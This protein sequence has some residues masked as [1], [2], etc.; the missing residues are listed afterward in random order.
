MMVKQVEVPCFDEFFWL[1]V[2][3]DST[4]QHQRQAIFHGS[5]EIILEG[6]PGHLYITHNPNLTTPLKTSKDENIRSITWLVPFIDDILKRCQYIELDASFKAAFP[7]VYTVPLAIIDNEAVPLGFT[8]GPTEKAELFL[9]FYKCVEKT[10]PIYEDLLKIPINT[11]EGNALSLFRRTLGL[12]QFLCDN[13]IINKFGNITLLYHLV[14]RLLYCV[15]RSQFEASLPLVQEI[16]KTIFLE[17]DAHQ[18]QFEEIIG[19]HFDCHTGN[20]VQFNIPFEPNYFW[21]RAPLNV[22]LTTNHAERFHRTMNQTCDKKT[23]M[24]R[25]IHNLRVRIT[26]K[27]CRFNSI[28]STPPAAR[29]YS[30]NAK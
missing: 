17:S 16:A 14:R 10:S 24:H 23:Y 20:W 5:R 3:S 27:I 12:R 4:L 28:S 11:D 25:K 22:G 9:E 7:Y 21:N 19:Y 1:N 26:E 15:S 18:S 6:F 30:M 2:L 13:L 29:T 8:I